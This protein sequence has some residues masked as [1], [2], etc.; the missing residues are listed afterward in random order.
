LCL[1]LAFRRL[2]ATLVS[3]LFGRRTFSLSLD[4]LD[5]DFFIRNDFSWSLGPRHY[6]MVVLHVGGSKASDIKLV[7][8]RELRSGKI[9]FRAGSIIPNEEH[10]HVVVRELHEEIGLV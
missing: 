3:E 8:Q 10:V 2:T 6:V 1:P 7:L 9:W 4:L 5:L